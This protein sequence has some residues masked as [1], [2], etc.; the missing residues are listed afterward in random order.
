MK[1]ALRKLCR[2][3]LVYFEKGEPAASYRGS[4]RII[5]LAAATLFLILSCVSLYF[6]LSAGQPAAMIPV[7]VFFV[8][9]AV[10]L[11]V[12][13]LG[14]DTAVARIWGLK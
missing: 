7:T 14:S 13:T 6:A 3:V 11:I 12:A 2:P 9:S 8:V 1:D 5:L 10:S 4:H